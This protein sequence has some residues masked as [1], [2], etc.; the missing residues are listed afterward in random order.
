MHKSQYAIVK[1]GLGVLLIPVAW[2]LM[3]G[4][5]QQDTFTFFAPILIVAALILILFRKRISEKTAN[6]LA[7]ALAGAVIIAFLGAGLAMVGMFILVLILF[8][9]APP[10]GGFGSSK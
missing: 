9:L 2:K 8:S 6:T 10:M 4:L 3:A 7:G 1:Y 5:W